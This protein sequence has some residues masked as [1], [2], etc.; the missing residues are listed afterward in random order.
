MTLSLGITLAF[1]FAVSLLFMADFAI[2][3]RKL[4]GKKYYTWI[5]IGWGIFATIMVLVV[6]S[7]TEAIHNSHLH[8]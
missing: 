6:P 7:V 4:T 1:L 3:L 2:R 8:P 5:M